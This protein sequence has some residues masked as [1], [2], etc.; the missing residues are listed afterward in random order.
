MEESAKRAIFIGICVFTAIIIISIVVIS[1]SAAN[2]AETVAKEYTGQGTKR[3]SAAQSMLSKDKLTGEEV[4]YL[5]QSA[6][7]EEGYNISIYGQP[8]FPEN[9][10]NTNIS[11]N[12]EWLKNYNENLGEYIKVEYKYSVSVNYG[13]IV[14]VSLMY[15]N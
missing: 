9:L 3:D 4:I 14:K 6:K 11:N 10:S 13:G 7:E 12:S 5:L 15:I 1:I 2:K 8:N